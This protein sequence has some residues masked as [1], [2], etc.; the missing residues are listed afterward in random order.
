MNHD[1]CYTVYSAPNRAKGIRG[2]VMVIS[3]PWLNKEG[4]VF[5]ECSEEEVEEF[6]KGVLWKEEVQ[7][8]EEG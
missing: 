4:C 5:D 8:V 2:G 6:K 1:G 3:A 7:T